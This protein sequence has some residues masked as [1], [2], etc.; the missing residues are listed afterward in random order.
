MQ[1]RW[2]N[3]LFLLL[4]SSVSIVSIECARGKDT[5][6][7]HQR[8]IRLAT[9]SSTKDSG[10]LDVLLPL[11]EKEYG[12]RVNVV[13]VGSGAA[14]EL[15]R[16]GDADV[17]LSHARTLEDA[18]IAEGYGLNDQEIMYNDFILLGPPDDPAKVKGKT[19]V[20]AFRKIGLQKA[21]FISRGDESGTHIR[22]ARLWELA[23]I[24]PDTG[25]FK[26]SRAGMFKT[27]LIAS[28]EKRYCLS[29]RGTYLSNRD[30]LNLQILVESD[31]QLFN[32][33]RVIAVNPEKVQGVN[34]GGAMAFIDF[35]A[36]P[37]TQA[38]IGKYGVSELGQQIFHPLVHERLP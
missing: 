24:R 7:L 13:S 14:L 23:E 38:I 28:H 34:Y 12:I 21:L 15:A 27:L 4:L 30:K 1:T 35:M 36:S 20:E 32:P 8:V 9:T 31:T 22:E 29:D 17:V 3:A 25:W 26:E 16:K 10:L 2:Y 18:F 5:P 6:K 33:Y 19:I 37:K 11:F